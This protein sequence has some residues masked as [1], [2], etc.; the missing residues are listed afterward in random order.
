MPSTCRLID[1]EPGIEV[2]KNK[3][4]TILM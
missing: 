1:Q 4:G 3:Q 2:V